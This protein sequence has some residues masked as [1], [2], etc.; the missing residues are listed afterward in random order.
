MASFPT[1]SG[2]LPELT[3]EQMREVDRAMIED[4]GIQLIQMMENAGRALA[5][6]ARV[7]FLDGDARA[8]R[9]LVLAGTGGNGG[10]ALVCAR[11]LHNAG[12]QVTVAVTAPE[13]LRDIPGQQYA[14]LQQMGV[15]CVTIKD[16]AALP[17]PELVIDGIIGYSLS[18]APAGEAAALINRANGSGAPILALD[19]PSGLDATTGIAYDLTIRATATLTLAL[20]KVGLRAPGAVEYV[21]ERYLAD[22][23]V[24]PG[25]YAR[26]PLNLCVGPIFS[27]G[28]VVYLDD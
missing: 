19:V 15:S 6:V 12:A 11:R 1:Y 17:Q 2:D 4:Y 13:R 25:L 27:R 8:R 28:D 9:L 23:S 16:L 14:I 10:G 7:R 21:G 24:P 20:P 5:H 22:L 3:T 18:G 26:S